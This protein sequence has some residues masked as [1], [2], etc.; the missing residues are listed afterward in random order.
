MASPVDAVTYDEAAHILGMTVAD[1]VAILRST[2]LLGRVPAAHS[3]LERAEVELLATETFHWK[4]AAESG[5]EA[6]Y[7]VTGQRAADLLGVN[8]ARLGQLADAGRL[9]F[10]RHQDGTRLYRR[11]QLEVI[12]NARSRKAPTGV[13]VW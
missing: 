4:T 10:V 5:D 8:R 9:P 12:A 1:A 13:R 6:T 11:H 3:I 2:R 7:W